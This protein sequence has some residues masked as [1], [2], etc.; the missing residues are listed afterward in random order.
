[1]LFT[2]RLN[3]FARSAFLRLTVGCEDDDMPPHI[4]RVRGGKGDLL[5]SSRVQKEINTI[6]PFHVG[7]CLKTSC[8]SISRGEAAR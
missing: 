3:F 1:M 8:G 6:Q 5:Y 2:E 7:S 4:D